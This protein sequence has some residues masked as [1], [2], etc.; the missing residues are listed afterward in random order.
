MEYIDAVTDAL[1][2]YF[3]GD[4]GLTSMRLD[5][6]EDTGLLRTFLLLQRESSLLARDY[7]DDSN[8][9]GQIRMSLNRVFLRICP[10]VSDFARNVS[11]DMLDL[12]DLWLCWERGELYITDVH[13]FISFR[14]SGSDISYLGLAQGDTGRTSQLAGRRLVSRY[15]LLASREYVLFCEWLRVGGEHAD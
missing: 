10:L 11:V 3:G 2:K 6:L 13:G 4:K 14:G 12:G 9:W 8:G 5:L 7:C 1:D 15:E